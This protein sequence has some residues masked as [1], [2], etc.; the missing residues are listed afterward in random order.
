[1]TK[2][3]ASAD[4][5]ASA[6]GVTVAHVKGRLKLAHLPDAAV[7]ALKA[8]IINLTVAQK[9]TT[10]D[11]ERLILGVLQLI[12]EGRITHTNQIDGVLHPKAVKSTDRR[13]VFVGAE[14]YGAVGGKIARDLFSDDVFFEDREVLDEVFAERLSAAAETV[15]QN[16]GWAW[17]MNHEDAY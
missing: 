2:S 17:V 7:E 11:D 8:K 1:M 13:A 16:E 5:I 9:L 14:A 10:A 3:Q 6:F 15:A 4:D 12:A